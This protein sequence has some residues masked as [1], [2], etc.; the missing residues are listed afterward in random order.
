MRDDGNCVPLVLCR[1]REESGDGPCL[2]LQ[3]QFPAR[4]PGPAAELVKGPKCAVLPQFVKRPARPTP[5]VYLGECL[6]SSYIDI[7][8]LCDLVCRLE[9]AVQ[10]ARIDS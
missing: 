8:T 3:H 1:E 10:R 2:H 5:A 6:L 9:T 7:V 4:G